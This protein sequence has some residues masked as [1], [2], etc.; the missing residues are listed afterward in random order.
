MILN[1]VLYALAT[2]QQLAT[3]QSVPQ[4][5]KV[6]EGFEITEDGIAV[7][8]P[9]RDFSKNNV[10]AEWA[11]GYPKAWGSEDFRFQEETP[12]P[13]SDFWGA[14]TQ[15][16]RYAALL[17]ESHIKFLEIDTKSILPIAKRYPEG[18][19]PQQTVLR[20]APGGEYDI[21]S[22]ASRLN[23]SSS[24]LYRQRFS[25]DGIPT[26]DWSTYSGTFQS[27]S[28]NY[29]M[30]TTTGV[31]YD[32]SRQNQTVSFI[33]EN[34][35]ERYYTA[36]SPDGRYVV[37]SDYTYETRNITITLWNATSGQEIGVLPRDNVPALYVVFSRDNKYIATCGG[38]FGEDMITRFYRV[39]DL[40][41]PPIALPNAR[42]NTCS[43]QWN[44]DSSLVA[45]M[46]SS[47]LYIWKFPELT[48][49]QAWETDYPRQLV[50]DIV[51]LDGGKKIGFMFHNGRWIYDFETNLK[52]WITNRPTDRVWGSNVLHYLEK[53][54]SFVTI[55]GDAS[56][57]FWKARN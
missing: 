2:L 3:S 32:M 30:V 24:H 15:N 23:D 20:P 48:L 19:R 10:S 51:W 54:D 27:F 31:I 36:L 22:S 52:W 18:A 11:P 57:R 46:Q 49:Y 25:S 9:I 41:A 37:T 47:S 4:P 55:G 56:V 39:D 1:Y 35:N 12:D 42:M 14:V 7:P 50:E 21:F 34:A 43:L 40:T 17:N 8:K 38:E 45:Q 44:L 6:L 53:T 5:A 26:G 28:D 33:G 29:R 16:E 13:Q